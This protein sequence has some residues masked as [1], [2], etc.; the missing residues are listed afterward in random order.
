MIFLGK[1]SFNFSNTNEPNPDPVPPAIEWVKINPSKLSLPSASLSTIS[2]NSSSLY[3]AKS[4]PLAQLL[5]APSLSK[6]KFSGLNKFL[7]S[8]FLTWLI[9]LGS[10]SIN[11][12]L[13][14]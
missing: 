6:K 14:I 1:R 12:A 2:N 9:T 4:Y 13:G 7:N 5:P 3:S 8:P 11:K 10:K